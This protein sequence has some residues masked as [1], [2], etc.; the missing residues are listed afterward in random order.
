MA[1]L[2]SLRRIR[3]DVR[4]CAFDRDDTVSECENLASVFPCARAALAGVSPSRVSARRRVAE[5][6]HEAA[7][8]CGS[9]DCG[10]WGAAASDAFTALR[11]A[12]ELKEDGDAGGEELRRAAVG[13]ARDSASARAPLTFDETSVRC[14]TPPATGRHGLCRPRHARRAAQSLRRSR[15]GEGRA[16][17]GTGDLAKQRAGAP[18]VRGA[19][20]H[21][22]C[23]ACARAVRGRRS[24]ALER[25]AATAPAE[26][27]RG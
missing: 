14:R 1:A 16:R 7:A 13:R 24:T 20:L 22:G 3:L 26:G 10:C 11:V 5:H 8:R 27:A 17:G 21:D 4:A 19:R 9:G 18:G 12:R 15:G 25:A 23:A 2:R 6:A